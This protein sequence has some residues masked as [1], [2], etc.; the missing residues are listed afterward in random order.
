MRHEEQP[1]VIHSRRQMAGLEDVT[2]QVRIRLLSGHESP[3]GQSS[4]SMLLPLITTV[5]ATNPISMLEGP[6]FLSLASE[7]GSALSTAGKRTPLFTPRTY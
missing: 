5:E 6:H 3:R 4:N 7:I 1:V 2:Q